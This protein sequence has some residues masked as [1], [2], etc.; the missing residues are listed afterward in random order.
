MWTILLALFALWAIGVMSG[1][2]G[3]LI[4]LLLAGAILAFVMNL[5]WRPGLS[6]EGPR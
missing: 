4:H 3:D 6:A 1:Y 2:A 5:I